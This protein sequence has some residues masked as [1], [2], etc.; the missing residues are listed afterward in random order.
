M[1]THKG[2]ARVGD[3][4]EACWKADSVHSIE[5]RQFYQTEEEKRQFICESFQ[6]DTNKY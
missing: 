4:E 3:A 6:L 5:N 2:G 1:D